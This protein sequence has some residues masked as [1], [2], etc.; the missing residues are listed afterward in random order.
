MKKELKKDDIL[1]LTAD[2][3]C[4]P[5]WVGSDHTREYIPILMYNN[6]LSKNLGIRDS[7]ADIGQSIAVYLGLPQLT[8]GRSFI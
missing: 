5:T 3:G 7:F 8:V 6:G 2:H 1:I 4:D